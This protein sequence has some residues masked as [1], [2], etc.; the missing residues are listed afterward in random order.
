M[1]S[2]LPPREGTLVQKIANPTRVHRRRR[3]NNRYFR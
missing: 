3:D 2:F 1:L